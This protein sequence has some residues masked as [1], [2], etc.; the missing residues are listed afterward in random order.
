MMTLEE[1]E[2]WFV[3][4]CIVAGAAFLVIAGYYF[5]AEYK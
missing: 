1:I 3:V 2:F 4:T 5:W